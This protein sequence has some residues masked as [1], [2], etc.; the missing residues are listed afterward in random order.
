M[1]TTDRASR[2]VAVAVPVPRRRIAV[3]LATLLLLVAGLIAASALA[4]PVDK[5]TGAPLPDGLTAA[6]TPATLPTS[7]EVETRIKEA[8]SATGLD[9]AAKSALV[10]TY[11][12]T[13]AYL[14]T[15]GK[16]GAKAADY[17]SA[18]ENA[19]AQTAKIRKQLAADSKDRGPSE[20]DADPSL[21]ADEIA[22]RLAK[23]QTATT[24]QETQIDELD[25][26][27]E[28]GGSRPKDA[29]ARIAELRQALDRGDAELRQQAPA[30]GQSADLTQANAWV[31]AARRQAQLAEI[32]ALEQELASQGVREDL[33]RAQRDQ[34]TQTLGQIKAR[35]SRLEALQVERRKADAEQAQRAT[36]AAQREAA[37]KHPLV[38][39][40]VE[41][42]AEIT[43][44]LAHRAEQL[45]QYNDELTQ[46]ERERK[47]VDE[48]FRGARERV[49]A[50]GLNQALG[51][52]L[53]DRRSQLPDLRQ[54]SKEIAKREDRIA[55]ASLS[56]IR[57]RE[58]QVRLRDM[59]GAI[60]ALSVG[61]TDAQTTRVRA[62]LKEALTQRRALLDK[63]VAA[64]DDYIRKQ[65]ELNFA[66]DQLIAAARVYDD[67][68]AEHLLWVRSTLPVGVETLTTLPS[69]VAWLL[70][71]TGWTEVL[72]A[73]V[74][75]LQRSP[76]TW[77]GLL[78][79]ALLFW[80]GG[81]LRQ[82][83]LDTAEPLRRVRTDRFRYTLR[84]MGLT[85]VAAAPI[86]LLSLVIGRAIAYSPEATPFTRAIGAAFIEVSI[87]FY[88]LR[89]FRLMCLPGGLADR[90]F[91]WESW[92]LVLIRRNLRWFTAY[93]VP[94]SLV[95]LAIYKINEAAYTGGLGRLSLIAAMIGFAVFFSRLFNPSTG[96]FKQTIATQPEGWLN[97]LRN[98]WYP[99]VI[100]T[101]LALAVLTLMG[102]LYTAGTLFQSMVATAWLAL[103][104]V[105]LHQAIV[106]WLVV[107]RR[108]L[109]LQAALDRQAA[110]RAQAESEKTDR[111]EA[112]AAA[113]PGQVEE[114]QVDWASLDEQ[115]RK[116]INASIAFTSLLGM[117]LIW[118]DMLPAFNILDQFALWH[119]EQVV[120][121]ATRQVPVTVADAGLVLAIVVAAIVAAKNL[122]ALLEIVLLQATSVTAGSRYAIRTLVSYAI[123]IAAV[124]AAF[125]ALGLSWSQVQWLVAALSVGIGFGLQEIVAN[126][127]SGIIILF[128][129][130]V[131]VGDVVTIGDTTG[132]VTNIQIRATTIRNWDRQELLVPNKDLITKHLLNWTLTDQINRLVIRVGIEYGNDPQIAM[133]GSRPG[134]GENPR[135]LKDPAPT[136]AFEAFAD[137]SLTLVLRCFVELLEYTDGRD[138]RAAPGDRPGP[139]GARH[140]YRLPPEGHPPGLPGAAGHP[141]E[142]RASGV[143]C[144][145]RAGGGCPGDSKAEGRIAAGTLIKDL[146]VRQQYATARRLPDNGL[147]GL[148]T[149]AG[150]G[151][152]RR[153][154]S[155]HGLRTRRAG[156]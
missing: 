56:Q 76:L 103:G 31:L 39:Q 110:R 136:V 149:E 17:A 11:K 12:R 142:P 13:L 66:T 117:W 2:P 37:D 95:A 15:V 101:P 144:G 75:D 147:P 44:A 154:P 111:Q 125:G 89:A 124:L 42:N 97:R 71:R 52:I 1:S 62:Q 58:E 100:G 153:I 3:P 84:A 155:R 68:L 51:Q 29:R 138:H 63:A 132:A 10:E 150:L 38:Q 27:I 72:R 47:R 6:P 53:I 137:N 30:P 49:E 81:R 54:Y 116:L 113:G 141:V 151:R 102:Y 80:N 105:V 23:A 146:I 48:D 119:T 139:A 96:V 21:S 36:E 34:L 25:K 118:A 86:P 152:R 85:L 115:T 98:L 55:E 67:F 40:A 41:L 129:R 120:D 5:G 60:D 65:G 26:L 77:L 128:E 33:Y 88:Y 61:D 50:G 104:L 7:S 114:P 24:L 69:A 8:E 18:L 19:P 87:G 90:H 45:A 127:I 78:A 32:R 109:A 131:R 59:D 123:T 143:G 83:I 126:F 145:G 20:L 28:T 148:G 94:V 134:G 91:R 79:V 130:P 9:E 4:A 70:S 93:I 99:L 122:P 107:T 156:G 82:A 35:Q 112:G 14:E 73:L 43:A 140:R 135:V 64:E 22:Q 57:Y 92:A 121:G 74:D 108:R 106:R 133:D 16:M 46:I